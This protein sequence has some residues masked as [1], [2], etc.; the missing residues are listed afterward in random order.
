MVVPNSPTFQKGEQVVVF[1]WTEPGGTHRVLGGS[2]GKHTVTIDPRSGRK[3]V[4]G[5][6]VDEF[7]HNIES[8]IRR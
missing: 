1:V 7:L 6:S 2:N 3:T 5:K 4:E 8:Y